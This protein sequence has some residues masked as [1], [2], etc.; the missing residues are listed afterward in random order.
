MI[1]LKTWFHQYR[2]W[3]KVE[4]W[5]QV[6]DSILS[7]IR[8]L[9][10]RHRLKCIGHLFR[11]E[12]QLTFILTGS[13]AHKVIWSSWRKRAITR[14]TKNSCIHNSRMKLCICRLKQRARWNEKMLIFSTQNRTMAQDLVTICSEIHKL[15]S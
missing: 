5:I 9:H 1:T 11:R 4:L 13:Q 7:R 12:L 6:M 8:Y 15:W 14:R 2:A 3:V 10:R